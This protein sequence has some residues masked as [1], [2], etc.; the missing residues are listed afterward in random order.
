MAAN[1]PFKTYQ[2]IMRRIETPRYP[3][4]TP[5]LVGDMSVTHI[6]EGPEVEEIGIDKSQ[7]DSLSRE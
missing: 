7:C 6:S 2:R 3:S 1:P 5:C 4:H